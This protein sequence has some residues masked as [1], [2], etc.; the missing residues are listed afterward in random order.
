MLRCRSKYNA[1]EYSNFVLTF[2]FYDIRFDKSTKFHYCIP[3]KAGLRHS[4]WLSNVNG[5]NSP[6]FPKSCSIPETVKCR[7]RHRHRHRHNLHPQFSVIYQFSLIHLFRVTD[8]RNHLP[9][10]H[11]GQHLHPQLARQL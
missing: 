2:M 3:P 10:N 8:H 11:P 5:Y 6:I 1:A 7:H 4:M 9:A